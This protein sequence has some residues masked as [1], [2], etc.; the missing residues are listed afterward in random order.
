MN[1]REKKATKQMKDNGC[2]MQCV[3]DEN[4]LNA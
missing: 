3:R 2:M 1:G 4:W